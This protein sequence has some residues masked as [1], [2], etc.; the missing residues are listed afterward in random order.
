MEN[1]SCG[2]FL[3][4]YDRMSWFGALAHCKTL[5]GTLHGINGSCNRSLLDA[6][7]GINASH[8]WTGNL[9]ES[10]IEAR[11]NWTWLDGRGFEEWEK[12]NIII[13]DVGCGGCGFWRNGTIYL[14]SNCTQELSYLCDND[15]GKFLALP[16]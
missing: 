4:V 13:P 14:A 6:P 8:F 1:D 11:A 5:N 10:N 2:S 15:Q 16:S 9:Y 3:P 7:Q 12:W